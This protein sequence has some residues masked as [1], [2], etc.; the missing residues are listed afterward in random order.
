MLAVGATEAVWAAV[1]AGAVAGAI[2]AVA[3]P[4]E[5]GESP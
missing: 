3:G 5:I 4:L 1:A 2:L